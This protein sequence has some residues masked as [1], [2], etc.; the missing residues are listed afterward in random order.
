MHGGVLKKYLT[1]GSTRTGF[2]A[3][4]TLIMVSSLLNIMI[5]NIMMCRSNIV[6]IGRD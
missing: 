5:S 3:D 2:Q 1:S 6:K 4:V